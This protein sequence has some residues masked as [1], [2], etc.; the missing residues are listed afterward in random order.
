MVAA[1]GGPP[2]FLDDFEPHLRRRRGDRRRHR[3][4]ARA[5]SP[6]STPAASA[7]RWSSSAAAGAGRTTRSTTRS[8]S[9]ACSGSAPAVEPD[10]PLARV[11]ARRPRRRSGRP[12]RVRA[13]YAHRRDAAARAPADPRA[14]GLMPRAILLVMDSVGCGG[15]PDAAAFG[16]EGAN[17]LG[18]IVR[19][20]ADGRADAGRCGPL[21][22]PNLAGL[23]LGA[24]IRAASGIDAAGLRRDARRR[25]GRGDRGVA[26]QGHAL[27]ALGAR[28][29]A[30]ALGLA[31]FPAHRPGDPAR[32]HCAAD[33]A[34]RACRARSATPIPRACRCFAPSAPSI[35]RPASRSSTPPPTACCRSPPTRR[36]SASSGSTRSAG[37]PRRSCTRCASAG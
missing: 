12:P 20:C 33:R 29:R 16:D 34:R 7:S 35:S 2:R 27:R 4:R 17:T 31:L 14:H 15:A 28:G 13:A 11:H 19:A 22:V 24:A 1:L 36:T 23:G 6:P 9:T 21:R 3:R 8:A 25:L 30:G 32:G 26:R 10:T 5:S 37:S 18:H